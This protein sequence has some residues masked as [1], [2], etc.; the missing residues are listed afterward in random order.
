MRVFIAEDGASL[1]EEDVRVLL[2][3]AQICAC[4][5]N[6]VPDI[7]RVRK[8]LTARCAEPS[9]STGL[10]RNWP[11]VKCNL[12]VGHKREHRHDR[13]DGVSFEWPRSRD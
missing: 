12:E 3:H 4:P 9:P 1:K 2:A 6:H 10:Y 7:E 13:F 8:V 5:Q 11:H